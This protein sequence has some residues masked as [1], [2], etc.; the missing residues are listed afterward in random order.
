MKLSQLIHWKGEINRKH[1]LIWG[2]ILFAVKY[3][4]DRLTAIAFDKDW[5]F[6]NY[7]IQ[8]DQMGVSALSGED[9]LFYLV[10]L[11]QSIPF[12]WFGT[13]LCVKRLRNAQLKTWLVIFFFIPFI[14]FILFILLSA[15]PQRTERTSAK[16]SFWTKVVPN[17][18]LGSALMALGIVTAVGLVITLLFVNYLNEYGWSLFV[19]VPFF[20]GFGSVLI[21]GQKRSLSYKEALGVMFASI[22]SFNA[23]IFI[24]AFEG[25]LCIAMGFPILLF[26]GCIGASVGYA[27]HEN[28]RKVAL[29]VFVLPLATML[30]TGTIEHTANEQPPLTTVVT[31]VVIDA[32]KQK[33]WNELVAFSHIDE[34]TEAIFKTGI[35]YPTHAEIS[36]NGVGAIRRCNFTT[37]TFV[38]PIT[39]WDE[40]NLLVFGVLDQPPPMVEWSIYDDIQIEHLDGYFKSEKGQ[41]KLTELPD[42]KVLLQGTTWYRHD[43][44]PTFYWR[45]WSDYILHQIHLRV[46]HHIK[47]KAEQ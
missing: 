8:A 43:I 29:N 15:I 2:I 34:P 6:I 13:V 16:D 36:G 27:I 12:I 42:G 37:G 14:N 44:W 40:P 4:L 31:E 18:K 7:I 22:L 24:L 10:L 41:F 28:N 35:A 21:Y 26:I 5:Y 19:G 25:I 1:Y 9:K 20:L 38:E 11:A 30:V 23:L 32:G 3:N 39:I 17:S 33:I 46:L 47:K 45:L